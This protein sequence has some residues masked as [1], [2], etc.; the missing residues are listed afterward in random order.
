MEGEYNGVLNLD[1]NVF[2][3]AVITPPGSNLVLGYSQPFAQ[4]CGAV[5]A[6]EPNDSESTAA[7]IG[8]G[9]IS[10][11]LCS[12][13]LTALDNEDFF[14]TPVAAGK[15]ISVTLHNLPQ[16]YGLGLLLDGQW[17]GSSYQ[18]GLVD[19][20]VAHI[21]NSGSAKVY[22]MV[23]ERFAD[24]TSSSLPYNLT[25]AVGDAPPPPPPP[26]PPP[27]TCAAFDAYDAPG[28]AGNWSQSQA[29]LIGFNT[30]ITAALCYAADKD[31]YA[32]DG[33][34]GQNVA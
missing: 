8:V 23:V 33:L 32:F 14:S 11:A 16:N 21:N 4:P 27:D 30:P 15:Q 22:T 34:V 25:V 9:T 10:A 6:Y 31:Y 26:P 2:Y 17:V 3:P 12:S 19:E 1:P 18:P 7:A 28:A 29:T 20:S 5:D 13:S 24:T